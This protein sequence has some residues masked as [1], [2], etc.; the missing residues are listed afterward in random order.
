MN[1][2]LKAEI[3]TNQQTL[4]QSHLLSASTFQPSYPAWYAYYLHEFSQQHTLEEC[5]AA[6]D[7]YKARRQAYEAQFLVQQPSHSSAK[8]V[9]P[10]ASYVDPLK[11]ANAE[12]NGAKHPTRTPG[13]R[14]GKNEGEK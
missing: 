13:Y 11:V 2:V 6:R 14:A 8:V 5:V 1:Q 9:D 4:Q 3:S 12:S 10:M 7:A